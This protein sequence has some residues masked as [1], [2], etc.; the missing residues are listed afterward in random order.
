MR[1]K[2]YLSAVGREDKIRAL[3][4]ELK[5]S[6]SAVKQLQP[7]LLDPSPQEERW[8]WRSPY[9]T[10][11]GEFP[12]DELTAYLRENSHV[13][14]LLK[15][16]RAGLKDVGPVIVSQ[17]DQNGIRG[18]SI[19]SELIGLLASANASLEIDIVES[20]ADTALQDSK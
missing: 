4:D 2:F 17:S 5:I 3:H 14:S 15:K 12:E 9:Q 18:C 10:C 1:S 20:P 11:N 6:G 16:H 7:N 8:L 13:L 19:S